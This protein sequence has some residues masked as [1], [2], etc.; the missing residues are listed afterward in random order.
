MSAAKSATT[1]AT[2]L[3]TPPLG[4][5]RSSHRVGERQAGRVDAWGVQGAR[6]DTG[7]LL[8]SDY[9]AE[10]F[11][12]RPLSSSRLLLFSLEV[13]S[14]LALPCLALPCF[15]LLC[16]A[17]PCRALLCLTFPCFFFALLCSALPCFAWLCFCGGSCIIT[18]AR[19]SRISTRSLTLFAL[20]VPPC[21]KTRHRSM[22]T[23][24]LRFPH[25]LASH[26]PCPLPQ[27]PSCI[28]CNQSLNP[29]PSS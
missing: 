20:V 13:L 29:Q 26:R 25:T 7:G 10:G 14:C 27:P 2:A 9:G 12:A 21:D 11:G 15:A 23:S 28:P 17:L 3:P 5:A 1:E 6:L 18:L 24:N 19:H 16:L 22:H 8:T 4:V